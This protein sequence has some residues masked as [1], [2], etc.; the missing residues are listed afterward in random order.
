MIVKFAYRNHREVIAD[1][2]MVPDSLHFDPQYHEDYN[3]HPGWFLSGMDLDKNARRS[4]A[5]SNI[6]PP[7]GQKEVLIDFRLLFE[8]DSI[9][10]LLDAAKALVLSIESDNSNHGDIISH[11]TLKNVAILRQILEFYAK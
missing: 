5:M 2:R 3:H 10:S 4:F 1:R 11:D 7:A 6:I 8:R 9:K